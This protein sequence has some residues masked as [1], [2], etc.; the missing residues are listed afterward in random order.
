MSKSKTSHLSKLFIVLF[1]IDN[2]KSN[3]K[4]KYGTSL[5]EEFAW[6]GVFVET[7][8]NQLFVVHIINN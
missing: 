3:F 7:F 2:F 5:L 1:D 6:T 8:D 4:S